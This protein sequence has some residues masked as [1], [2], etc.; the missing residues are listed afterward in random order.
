[1]ILEGA[2]VSSSKTLEN[3]MTDPSS[4][5]SNKGEA[6]NNFE[7]SLGIPE[8][9][10]K[11][12]NVSNLICPPPCILLHFGLKNGQITLCIDLWWKNA[13][14][15]LLN[16]VLMKVV[17][18]NSLF[19][20][21]LQLHHD[22][23][24]VVCGA[25]RCSSELPSSHGRDAWHASMGNFPECLT[26]KC[27]SFTDKTF[28]VRT[29]FLQWLPWILRMQRPGKP[30]TRKTIMMTNRMR[31]LE[32]KEKTSKSLLANVLDMDDDFR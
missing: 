19:R 25:Y 10:K 9:L 31:E 2:K 27:W 13:L 5:G 17:N 6:K 28:Q 16:Y 20:H 11:P 7:R 4:R 26:P 12:R 29:L 3:S 22:D 14:D 18:E 32:L 21:L 30:I 1:M 8:T 23:G 15:L 24:G